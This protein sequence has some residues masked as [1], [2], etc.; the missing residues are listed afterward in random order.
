MSQRIAFLACALLALAACTKISSSSG[1]QTVGR[2]D[3]GVLRISDISDPSTLDPMLTGADVAYQLASYS[4][5]YLVQLDGNGELTPVLCE[6]VPTIENGDISKDGLTITYHLR[7]GVTWQDGVAF[8]SADVAATWKQVMNPANPVIIRTG[9]EVIER[10][11]TPD[12][13]TAVLHLKQPYAPLTTRFLA[14]IQEGPIPVLPAHIIA[15]EK[16]LVH[17]PLN[18]KPVGTGPFI[19]QSWEHNGRLVYIANPHYWRGTPKLREIIFQAQP[20][21]STEIIGFRTGELDADFDTGPADLPSYELLDKMRISR[22]PSLRLAVVVMNAAVG[23]PLADKRL[24]HAIAY[25]INRHET[26]HKIIHDVGVMA[27]EFLPAWS[28]AYTPDV[29]RYDYDP[30]ESDALLDAAGWKPGPDGIREKDGQRLT[31]VIIGSI[32]SDSTKRFNTVLQSYLRAVGIEA[33]IKDYPYGIVFDYDGPIR[34]GRY[35]IASYT[36]SVN[37]DPSALQDDGCDQFAPAGANESRLCDPQVDRLERQAL[38]IYDR[39]KRRPMYAQIER[40]RMDDLGTFPLY[41]RDRVGVV[42]D[43]LDGY[44]PSRGI[45]PNWN[46]WQWSLR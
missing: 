41:Y 25:A 28:W 21:Q 15:G 17:S 10:I 8:T 7:K 35:D 9:Y 44:V 1:P 27:D 39:S 4:L 18:N 23:H 43:D 37:Y 24:R 32:G 34:Q 3:A 33:I 2:T 13:W 22:S 45:M 20:S 29:P 38:A 46:A 11:D 6:R 36:Y 40:L 42:T 31:V 19:V 26:L 16:D 5:E 12:R 30:R 14:G